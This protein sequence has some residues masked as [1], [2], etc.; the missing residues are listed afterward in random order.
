LGLSE[1]RSADTHLK[2]SFGVKGLS[3]WDRC[4]EAE[5]QKG[6][7]LFFMTGIKIWGYSPEGDSPALSKVF[8]GLPVVSF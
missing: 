3:W 4:K 2:E 7:S 6:F 5:I 1:R 8:V